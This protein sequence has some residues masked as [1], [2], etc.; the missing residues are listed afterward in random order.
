MSVFGVQE[1][2]TVFKSVALCTRDAAVQI[3]TFLWYSWWC[4]QGNWIGFW[5]FQQFFFVELLSAW[6]QWLSG[7]Q[8]LSKLI[9]TQISAFHSNVMNSMC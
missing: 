6:A 7:T 4:H 2:L 1:F 8:F 5:W 3:F 9:K